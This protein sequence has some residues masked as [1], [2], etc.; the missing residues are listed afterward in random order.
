MSATWSALGPQQFID[1]RFQ[2][3]NGRLVA[4]HVRAFRGVIARTVERK[5]E[6]EQCPHAHSKQSAARQCAVAAAKRKNKEQ[7][8]PAR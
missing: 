3:N 1:K 8:A 6:R 7:D 2:M 5:T 4:L